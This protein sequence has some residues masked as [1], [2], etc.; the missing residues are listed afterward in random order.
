MTLRQHDQAGRRIHSLNSIRIHAG[1]FQALGQIRTQAILSNGGDN[2]GANSQL[3]GIHRDV[4][5]RAAGKPGISVSPG[6]LSVFIGYHVHEQFADGQEIIGRSFKRESIFK[7]Y[8]A[9]SSL[10]SVLAPE[11]PCQ[12]I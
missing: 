5:G 8:H 2:P 10:S 11:S 3:A 9:S 12:S 6:F 4:R 7:M 1:G